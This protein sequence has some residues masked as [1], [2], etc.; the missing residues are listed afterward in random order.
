MNRKS[1]SRL[2]LAI[3]VA[4][5]ISAVTVGAAYASPLQDAQQVHARVNVG[6]GT[7]FYNWYP[8]TI[9][10]SAFE[11]DCDRAAELGVRIARASFR[12][13]MLEPQKGSFR[14]DIMDY[15]VNTVVNRAKPE[16]I[17]VLLVN[18]ACWAAPSNAGKDYWRT[19]PR[20]IQ[21]YKDYLTAIVHRYGDKIRYW[22]IWN[23]PNLS[24]YWLG[25]PQDYVNLL[26]ASYDAI[27]AVDPYAKVLGGDC[28]GSD[29][30]YIKTLCDLG[31]NQY[32][33][34][35]S[36]HPYCN[37]HSP[38]DTWNGEK[39][40]YP[41]VKKILDVMAANVGEEKEVWFTEL[42]WA[43]DW[44]YWG[45]V[46][47]ENQAN[48]M[49]VSYD[50]ANEKWPQVEAYIWFSSRDQDD[51][52][53]GVYEADGSKR[54]SWGT[55]TKLAKPSPTSMPIPISGPIKAEVS[56]SSSNYRGPIFLLTSILGSLFTPEMW[57]IV[58]STLL[59]SF[60]IVRRV[61]RTRLQA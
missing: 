13:D 27:K 4:T 12:W 23:E 53:W 17:V 16:E 32:F 15:I 8:P 5:I 1:V 35:L 30:E 57:I 56:A 28:S 39:N 46:T 7:W 36:V 34:I 11:Q 51:G 18:T 2:S 20:D 26:K 37:P 22:E 50:M 55:F 52:N 14:W 59:G 48:Y 58:S 45:G 60:M 25:T 33:D 6:I 31:A 49:K 40:G 47:K 43:V 61:Q 3:A 41:I 29:Y 10:D 54:P 38:Q 19:P 44:S 9:P 24:K 21:G 42:A